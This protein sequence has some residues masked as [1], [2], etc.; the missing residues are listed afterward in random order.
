MWGGDAQRRRLGQAARKALVKGS[1]PS[2]S[3]GAGPSPGKR[4]GLAALTSANP[5]SS[6]VAGAGYPEC[7]TALEAHW[8]NL[9]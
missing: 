7:Y 3:T 1:P 8:I 4:E 5:S 2:R 9:R 6:M